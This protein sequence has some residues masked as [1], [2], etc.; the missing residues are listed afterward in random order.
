MQ[1]LQNMKRL[2]AMRKPPEEIWVHRFGK[3]DKT[4]T[5]DLFPGDILLLNRV[6]AK[7][8]Q[9]IPCDLLLLSG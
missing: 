7:K 9:N 3:W 8:K 2:R 1:R 6:A 4:M 5:H